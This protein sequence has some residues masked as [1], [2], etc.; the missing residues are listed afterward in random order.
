M[1]ILQNDGNVIECPK[2]E[3]LEVIRHSAAHIM[4]QAVKRLYPD[5]QFAFGPATE[6]GFYY[7][8]DP[9]DAKITDEDVSR[10]EDEMRKIVKENLPFKTFE[11]PRAEAIKLM[12]DRG[13][14]YKVEH[15]G[16]F[17]EGTRITFF[18][19]GEYIDMCTGPH[20][21]YTKALKAFKLTA[22]SGAYWRADQN[23]KMLTRL[24]GTAFAT[25][26]ELA[27]FEKQQEEA[28]KR[29]HRKI[30][31][32]MDIFTFKDVAAG[33]PFMLPNG[34]T[35]RDSLMK[36]WKELHRREGYQIIET[37]IMMDQ[38]LWLKS[39]HWDHYKDNMYTSEIDGETLCVKPMNCPGAV[40]VYSD[41]PRS[42]RELPLR[43][44]EFGHVHRYEKSGQLHG[45][46]RV[47][48]FHQDDAHIFVTMDQIED[49][50]KRIVGLI[51]EV[52][53]KFGFEYFVELS[54]MPE[55]HMGSDEDWEKATSGL[56]NALS[57]M[58]IDY[59]INEGDGAFYGPKIDFHLKDCIG[60]TWQCGT[61]QLDFQMPQNFE[62]SYVG[63]D[64]SEHTPVMLHRVLFGSVERFLG[65]LIEHFAGKFPVWIAPIQAKILP[66]SDKSNEYA[67]S[68]YDKLFD[69][70][71]RVAIDE[72]DEK[73][74]YK[75]R[76]AQQEQRIPYMLVL[77]QNE[78]NDNT[79]TVRHRDTN[80]STTMTVDEFTEAVLKQDKER[81]MELSEFRENAD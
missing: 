38:S 46:M 39:G 43:M 29:D 32:Q 72:R 36:Y 50:I 61:V 4:A 9:G 30:G 40:L 77:G 12:E 11:L 70:G 58:G 10:I 62:I 21:T 79:V 45:L 3:E 69:A 7:D 26:D 68:V 51:D 78:A 22:L 31:R 15:I 20:I 42:Y 49:E 24:N 81:C 74:G 6:K 35:I 65:I 19:Q 64:G 63:E 8:I 60:R 56:S 41:R 53:T 47:R 13:E 27:E 5:A 48:C 33:F 55:D 66:V 2:E 75:I 34:M 71:I 67:R 73:I 23:N 57:N 44:A 1:K 37:P 17:P 80:K 18:Q 28:L 59:I 52:Y 76:E 16:D 54:T 14:T 25:K